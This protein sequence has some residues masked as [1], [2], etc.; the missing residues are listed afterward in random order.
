MKHRTQKLIAI[1]I[2]F[3]VTVLS[4]GVTAA[5]AQQKTPPAP[6][7]SRPIVLPKITEQKLPNGLTV[8]MAPL[9][10]V[11]KVTVQLVLGAGLAAESDRRPGIA[12]LSAAVAN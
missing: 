1:L 3:C 6:G 9:P 2:A 5:V 8:V 10:N 4:I 7:P 12:A 11:P